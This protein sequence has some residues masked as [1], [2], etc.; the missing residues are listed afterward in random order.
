MF[1]NYRASLSFEV[2]GVLEK[3]P[4]MANSLV[5]EKQSSLARSS[6]AYPM[7]ATLSCLQRVH[8]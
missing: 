2:R 5:N 3:R 1:C 4:L 8:G 6:L 7:V